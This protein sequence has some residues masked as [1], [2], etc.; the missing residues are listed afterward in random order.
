MNVLSPISYFLKLI[1]LKLTRRFEFQA[2]TYACNLKKGQELKSGLIK[3]ST[4]N[5]GNLL[6]DP[7]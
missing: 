3:L 6:S 7:L 4:K 1:T 5:A 2:D